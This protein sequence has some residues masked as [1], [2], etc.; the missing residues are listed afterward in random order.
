MPTKRPTLR[1]IA[2][3]WTLMGHPAPDPEWPLRQ[4]L[5]AIKEAGF[6]GV[7]WAGSQ[8][9]SDGLREFELI[10]V[11]GMSSGNAKE[12]PDTLAGLKQC[13]ARHINVQ[14]ADHD[15]TTER[16]L[17]LATALMQEGERLGVEPAV[18]T[19]RD[20]C[21]ETPEKAY[22]L[23]DAYERCTGRL[24]PLSL[25]FSHFA[26]V[27]HLA[28]RDF[29]SRLLVRPDLVKR[30]QQFHFRPF[31]GHHAQVPVTDGH[32]QLT[33]EVRDWLPFAEAVFRC[34]LEAN[35]DS[36]R[37]IFVCPE[38]GP[39]AGGYSLSSF[40]NSW[41]DAKRLRCE[42]ER[43]WQRVTDEASGASTSERAGP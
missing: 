27:K 25:D 19:H 1:H 2:N 21:T 13:G 22:A 35:G 39:L 10:F 40:P 32:G 12:F 17:E 7:C 30:A 28:P 9:L 14:L 18:E 42:I 31:N 15:T 23:S 29:A 16:A 8:E 6:D 38:M 3:L 4:K 36:D 37:E 11:G 43:L 33:A 24:L 34:W 5:A 26:V 41:E 20:T